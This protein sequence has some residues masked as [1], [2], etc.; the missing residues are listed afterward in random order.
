MDVPAAAGFR[1]LGLRP[2]PAGPGDLEVA[3]SLAQ[4]GP[5]R[6]ELF[7]A[8]GR[9]VLARDLGGLGAGAHLERLGRGARVSAG[10]YFL[11]LTQGERS[12][13][14]RTVVLGD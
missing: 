9:R 10:I 6:L 7:D 12:A 8:G 13:S 1:L 5:V 14:L 11:R 3:F 4:A 2:Q